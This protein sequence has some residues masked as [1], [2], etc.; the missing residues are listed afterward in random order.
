MKPLNGSQKLS[1]KITDLENNFLLKEVIFNEE[2]LIF[3]HFMAYLILRMSDL[4]NSIFLI[5]LGRVDSIKCLVI[6][7]IM[8]FS[9][10]DSIISNDISITVKIRFWNTTWSVAKV[11]QNRVSIF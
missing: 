5:S 7:V 6:Q 2:Y 11:F 1:S 4:A 8:S 9:S 3:G 10:C